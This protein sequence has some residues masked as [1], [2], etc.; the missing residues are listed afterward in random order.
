MCQNCNS[1]G[2]GILSSLPNA[3]SPPDNSQPE[4]NVATKTALAKSQTCQTGLSFVELK[5][6]PNV[7]ITSFETQEYTDRT[8][9]TTMYISLIVILIF[10]P[11][12]NYKI[13]K[14]CGKKN[15]V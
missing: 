15:L 3:I 2:A 4:N 9:P 5:N 12:F 14:F 10:I 8:N 13:T 7:W 6:V 1:S 11:Y